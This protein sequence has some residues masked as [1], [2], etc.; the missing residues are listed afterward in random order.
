MARSF[1]FWRSHRLP[2]FP[3]WET[4]T[5]RA[6]PFPFLGRWVLFWRSHRLP[7]SILGDHHRSCLQPPFLFLGPWVPDPG[8]ALIHFGPCFPLL[9]LSLVAGS[10]HTERDGTALPLPIKGGL[11]SRKEGRRRRRSVGGGSPL[12]CALQRKE[13]GRRTSKRRDKSSFFWM[14][15]ALLSLAMDTRTRPRPRHVKKENARQDKKKAS[16]RAHGECGLF[17]FEYM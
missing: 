14:I 8:R 17:F 9:A 1:L 3:F 6:C 2:L 16:K 13:Q 15:T 5:G 10:S 12:F 7:L 4:A 11:R